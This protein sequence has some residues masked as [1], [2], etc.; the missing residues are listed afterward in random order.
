MA[1]EIIKDLKVF[2]DDR[3]SLF[4]MLRSADKDIPSIKQITVTTVY[5]GAVKAWHRHHKQIDVTTCVKGNVKLCLKDDTGEVRV[6]YLGEQSPKVIII[7]PGIWHGY[8]ALNNK[9][10]VIVYATSEIFNPE[11]EER[12]PFDAFGDVWTVKHK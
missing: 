5:A 1:K 2:A 6:H 9:E 7:P 12:K 3:G 11:D 8:T 10:A 4:E